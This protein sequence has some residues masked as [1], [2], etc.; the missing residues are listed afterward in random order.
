MAKDTLTAQFHLTAEFATIQALRR[1]LAEQT[2]QHQL[3]SRLSETVT[4]YLADQ[5]AVDFELETVLKVSTVA[6]LRRGARLPTP[7]VEHDLLTWYDPYANQ[8]NTVGPVG[9][10]EWTTWLQAAEHTSFRYE[11]EHGSFTAIKEKRRG[12]LVW[13]AHRRQHGRLKRLYL[14]QAE[15]LNAAKLAETARQLNLKSGTYL[16]EP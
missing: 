9:S 14:G 15:K 13:Y 6:R 16:T 5:T 12:H 11:S 2:V 10:T 4:A 3:S 8:T 1:A 7:K